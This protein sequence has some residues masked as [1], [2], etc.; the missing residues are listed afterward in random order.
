MTM[1]TGYKLTDQNMRTHGGCQWRLGEWHESAGEGEIRGPGWLHGYD[2]HLLAMF[3][4]PVHSGISEL[5]M[6]RTELDG[7]RIDD[8]GL[9]HGHA[10]MR[11]VEE[12]PVPVVTNEQRVR[13]AIFVCL[14]LRWCVPLP[15]VFVPWAARWLSGSDRSKE[16]AW[17]VL[18]E[19]D[20]APWAAAAASLTVAARDERAA[21]SAAR[22]VE[23]AAAQAPA[24]VLDLI[25]CAHEAVQ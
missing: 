25:S 5:R 8:R 20:W 18:H 14:D 15:D 1:R 10:R 12:L 21:L 6:F 7:A 16:A 19:T 3:M 4:T 9:Q 2:D 17:C 11:L 23:A 13:F 24:G 22:S